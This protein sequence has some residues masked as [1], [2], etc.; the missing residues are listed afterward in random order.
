MFWGGMSYWEWLDATW[1]NGAEGLKRHERKL[2]NTIIF[3]VLF[4]TALFVAAIAGVVI[5]AVK[6]L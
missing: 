4:S 2:R 5:L 3:M 6:I 1:Q